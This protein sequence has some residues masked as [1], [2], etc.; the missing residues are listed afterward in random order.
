[1]DLNTKIE[2]KLQ[3]GV[4][5]ALLKSYENVE[6]EKGGYLRCT[7]DID[8]REITEIIFPR[9]ANYFFGCLRKQ[10][11]MEDDDITYLELLETAKNIS[12]NLYV[13]YNQYGRNIAYHDTEAGK[14]EKIDLDA[15]RV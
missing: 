15:V 9:S 13:S 11:A 10:L 14:A 2:K 3:E 7:W 5:I 12:I 1:M 6:N 4:H 8:G